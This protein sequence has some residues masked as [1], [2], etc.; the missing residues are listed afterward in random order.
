MYESW[1]SICTEAPTIP[2]RKTPPD[3]GVAPASRAV[4]KR[5]APVASNPAESHTLRGIDYLDGAK[6]RPVRRH[7]LATP[8]IRGRAGFA[9]TAV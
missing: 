4:A 7:S 3:C 1:G 5:T 2:T 9:G 6:R 8:T